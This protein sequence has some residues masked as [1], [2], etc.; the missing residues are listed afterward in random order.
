MIQMEC[1]D[2]SLGY[3]GVT[4]CEHVSFTVRKGDYF[5]IVGSNGSGKSTLMRA[6]LRLKAPLG[7]TLRFGEGISAREV[8]YLPQQS[9][10]QRDFPASVREVVLSGCVG[11]AGFRFFPTREDRR[12]AEEAM[13]RLDVLSLESRS[14]GVLSGGQKQ[15]VLLARAL[16]AAG[17][18]LLLDEPVSGLDPDATAELYDTIARLNGE[19]VTVIMITHDLPAVAKY[20]TS[21][22]HMGETPVFYPTVGEYLADEGRERS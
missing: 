12:R 6:L 22:L 10:H 13:R 14:F 3:E 17:S 2:L 1:R 8:G 20:A 16:V 9:V 15:R 7:G 21:V 19:G 5:C 4:V 18:L 11:G